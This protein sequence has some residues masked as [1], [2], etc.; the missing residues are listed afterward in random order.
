MD[1]KDILCWWIDGYPFVQF[2]GEKYQDSAKKS[3]VVKKTHFMDCLL[4]LQPGDFH[5]AGLP[6]KFQSFG[7]G[8]VFG[9]SL[10]V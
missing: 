9:R 1:P 5:R 8:P 7:K 4:S 2:I 3:T 6:K 10:A